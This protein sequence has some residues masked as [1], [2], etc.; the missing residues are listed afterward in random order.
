MSRRRS[1]LTALCALIVIVGGWTLIRAQTPNPAPTSDG[2]ATCALAT[3]PSEVAETVRL[4]R[5]GGPFPFP[6]N[7][8]AVFGNRERHLPV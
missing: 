4:I 8:G 7:D 6:H 5:T 1:V 2:A 3:L